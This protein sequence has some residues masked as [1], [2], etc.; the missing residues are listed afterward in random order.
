MLSM[1]TMYTKNSCS[2]YCFLYCRQED[3]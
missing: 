1:Q 3:R 2:S